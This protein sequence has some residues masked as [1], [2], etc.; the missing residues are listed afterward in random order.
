MS[1][2][3]S[4]AGIVISFLL[5]II[6]TYK[7]LHVAWVS[8][9]AALVIMVT[10][11]LP[12]DKTWTETVGQGIGMMAGTLIPI[13][14]AGAALGKIITLTGATD[15]FARALMGL[16]SKNT[17]SKKK[18]I[19]G[20]LIIIFITVLM[21]FAGIDNFA[22]VFTI[23]A[24]S[25]SVMAEVGIPR[26]F[27]GAL[28]MTAIPVAS[29][30]PGN[31][32]ML[33]IFAM[34]FLPG[35]T[36][37]SGSGLAIVSASFLLVFSLIG[38]QR[39]WEKD[40]AAGKTFEREGLLE[41]KF[42]KENLPPWFCLIVPVGIVFVCFNIA[43]ISAFFSLLIGLVA[44][45]IVLFPWIPYDKEKYH[46]MLLG[47]TVTICNEF[48]G[49]AELAGLPC[50]ILIN[51]AY[52]NIIGVSPA[53]QAFTNV[54]ST[55]N[56]GLHPYIYYALICIVVI[57]AAVSFSGLIILFDLASKLFIPVLGVSAI[58]AQ[59]ILYASTMVLDSLPYGTM[60]VTMLLLTKT[61]HKEGYP[62]IFFTTV[63]V[64]FGGTILTTILAMIFY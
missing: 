43:H 26:R 53:F 22:I 27:M 37:M 47:K 28:I 7:G 3:I 10:S 35:V 49:G 18:R 33:N 45:V 56:G 11:G 39:M 8:I 54:L 9:L 13:F 63:L 64:T 55:Y 2:F 5:L 58:A 44:S 32:S 48:N 23:I 36:A 62:P 40:I 16:L 24:I 25:T 57:G 52:G 34:Q 42:N 4:I 20:A 61:K 60:V 50:I 12:I 14:L 21:V 38:L 41:A 30:L 59:R 31:P 17:S 19:V 29:L 15:S 6:L 51:M 46:K 1:L